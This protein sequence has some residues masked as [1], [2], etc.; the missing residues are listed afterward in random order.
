MKTN[1]TLSRNVRYNQRVLLYHSL[2]NNNSRLFESI[3]TNEQK[4]IFIMTN[5]NENVMVELAK[6]IFNAM[7][8]RGWAKCMV[9]REDNGAR[10]FFAHSNN[11]A[12]TFFA[13]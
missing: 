13:H 7:Y 4:C 10:T 12:K 11:G 5:E 6:F 9:I 1:V 3:T 2:N 8:L